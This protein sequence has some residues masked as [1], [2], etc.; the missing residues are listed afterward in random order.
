MDQV[1]A[2]ACALMGALCLRVIFAPSPQHWIIVV[3][4]AAIL[5]LLTVILSAPQTGLFPSELNWVAGLAS[6]TCSVQY[7][8]EIA[9]NGSVDQIGLALFSIAT[10]TL[11][12][13][14][15]PENPASISE[16]TDLPSTLCRDPLLQINLK[17]REW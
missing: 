12:I 4:P 2:I 6:S 17:Q 10:A 5:A 7:V 3:A 1:A 13:V 11:G 9:L 15:N 14:L 16:K 8:S